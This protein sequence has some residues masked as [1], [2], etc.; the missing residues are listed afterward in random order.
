[1]LLNH[2]LYKQN[3]SKPCN[4]TEEAILKLQNT[5]EQMDPFIKLHQPVTMLEDEK[6]F[7]HCFLY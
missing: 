6:G 3:F 1:M 2:Q 5:D 7:K 4:C